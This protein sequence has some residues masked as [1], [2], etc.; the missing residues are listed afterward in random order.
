MRTLFTAMRAAFLAALVLSAA[1]VSGARAAD[2]KA[3]EEAARAEGEM[4]WYVSLYSQAIAEKTAAAFMEKYPGLNVVVVRGTTGGSFQRLMQDLK[5][6]VAV[7]S[8][9]STTGQ[10]GQYKILLDGSDL[11]EY[12]PAA[13]AGLADY[14]KGTIVPGYTYPMGAGLLAMAYNSDKIAKADEPKAW[15]DLTDPK[16][17][18]RLALGH[19]ATSGFDA[20]WCVSMVK[21]VGWEFY[22]ALA[23]NDPLIQRSTFDTLTAL[24]SGERLVA[25]LPDAFAIDAQSKGN[26]IAIVYPEDG[27]EMILG[28]TAILKNAPQPNMAK[29]FTEFLLDVE[30]AKVMAENGYISLRPEVVTLLSGGKPADQI[31]LLPLNTPEDTERALPAIIEDWRDLFGQ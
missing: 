1:A 17:K 29:L 11:A 27:S 2:L 10:G 25:T 18:G 4:T 28:Y 19:P 7:A 3:L 13:A 14:V 8:V 24:N 21:K 30:H 15:A 31:N 16:W 6:D 20:S 9:F 26:P 22:E 5:N 23:A 12:A